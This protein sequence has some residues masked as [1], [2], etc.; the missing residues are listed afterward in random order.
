[1]KTGEYYLDK[2]MGLPEAFEQACFQGDWSRAKYLYDTA[3]RAA[4]FLEI[5]EEAE[6]KLFGN[7]GYDDY[8]ENPQEGLFREALCSRAYMEC[9]VKL[10]Q[11]Y[12][13]E[14]YRRFGEP[15]KFYPQPRYPSRRKG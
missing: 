3:I 6:R 15:P 11:D 10:Y 8:A 5:P 4:E 13:H 2:L 14:S 9:T 1:M 7:H 12:A